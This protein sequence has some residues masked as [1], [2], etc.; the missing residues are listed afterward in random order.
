MAT[1]YYQIERSKVLKD[2]TNPI[3]LV[4]KLKE[5]GK[6]KRF[7]FYTGRSAL[8]KHWIGIGEGKKVASKASGAG[9][10]NDRLQ[11]LRSGADAII[12]N[13]RNL[14]INLTPEYFKERFLNEVAGR[15]KEAK[16][17]LVQASFFDHL[18]R[19]IGSKKGVFQPAT[20]KFTTRSKSPLLILRK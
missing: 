14:K 2:G 16:P 10:T 4:V 17:E 18:Q 1:V 7:R 5:N 13:A 8:S 6:E 19:F 20:I 9:V 3:Y 12:T 15:V 11:T